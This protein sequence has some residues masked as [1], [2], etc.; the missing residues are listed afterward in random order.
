MRSKAQGLTGLA[1]AF[2]ALAIV[3]D[4]QAQE[5]EAKTTDEVVAIDATKGRD[6]DE[7]QTVR[8]RIR[9]DLVPAGSVIVSV[10]S[11]T[12]PEYVLGAVSSNEV[13]EWE[14]DTRLYAGGF[15]LVARGGRR[16]GT[17]VSRAINVLGR[18]KVKWDL[19]ID[20]VRV[21]RV[22]VEDEG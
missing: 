18:A 21:E 2:V 13:R 16:G 14:I 19:G 12:R 1:L 9:N 20:L 6:L 5:T 11:L 10:I 8:V 15:R 17:Q 4:A 3:T 22:E 7:T